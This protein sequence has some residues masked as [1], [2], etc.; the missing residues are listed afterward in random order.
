MRGDPTF[1]L[2]QAGIIVLPGDHDAALVAAI[3]AVRVLKLCMHGGAA[4]WDLLQKFSLVGQAHEA[5]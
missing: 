5:V 3:S 4:S 2:G 1:L